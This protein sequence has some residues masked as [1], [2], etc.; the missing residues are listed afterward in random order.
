M[1]QIRIT[2][3]YD[4]TNYSG[5]Q[6]QKKGTT[7]QGLLEEA[8]FSVTGEQL[9]INGAARTDAGVHAFEQVAVFKTLSRLEPPVLLRALNAHLTHDIRVIRA[10]ECPPDFHPRYDAKSKTYTYLI[11][12]QGIY[13]TF[14]QRY[15]WNI[16]YQLN[17][18]VM[19]EAA[20]CLVGT[21]DF[22]SFRASK[23][24]S[25]HP[26]RTVSSLEVSRLSSV[27][28][29][30]FVFNTPVVKIT[31]QAN[32]FLRHMARN[33]V[34]T[35][36]DIGK[37]KHHPTMMKGILGSKDRRQAGRTAPARGLFLERIEY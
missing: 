11:S 26:V 34:G 12:Q 16:P 10:E 29:I 30:S 33:I 20:E 35:L 24:S 5:W 13:S 8:L 37:G 27:E 32:A 18:G 19:Q 31:I 3:Q 9:R 1:R 6:I 36:V 25:K 17:T 2:L 14:L 15:S 4:G 7:I 21:H 22:S 23:C 28:F